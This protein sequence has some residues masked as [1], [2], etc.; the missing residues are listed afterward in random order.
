MEWK[1][2]HFL[3]DNVVEAVPSAWVFD[4]V[5]YWPP[6]KGSKLTQAI[7]S[8][9]SPIFGEWEMCQIRQLV[10]GQIYSKFIQ[11]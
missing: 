8:C 10:N 6:Y 5:C 4:D 1:I 2:I 11:C 3:V 7:S 9:I